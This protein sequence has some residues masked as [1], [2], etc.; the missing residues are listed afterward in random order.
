MRILVWLAIL[1]AVVSMVLAMG[2][3]PTPFPEG[4]D[5]A[6][7]LM[8]GVHDVTQFNIELIDASRSTQT[9]GDYVGAAQ[10]RLTATV[11]HQELVDF[12]EPEAGPL[13]VYSHG[14]SSTRQDGAYLAELLASLGYVVVAVDYPLTN[15]DA[16]GGPLVKDVVNQPGDV[17]FI[18]DSLLGWS[19]DSGHTLA[20]LI[21]PE[22]IGITG[23]SL[24]GMTTMLTAYHP[25]L[26]D[27]RIDAALAIAGPTS[28][29]THRFF[30]TRTDLPFMMIA[31]DLD[32]MVPYDK[33]ALPVLDRIPHS[34]LVTI[35]G[36]SHTGFAGTVGILR[37]LNNPDSVGCY[38]VT[39]ALKEEADEPWFYL[40]G[41]PEQ[42]INYDATNDLCLLDPLP[43]AIN[44]LRQQSI[45]AAVVRSF[46]E[47]QFGVTAQVREEAQTY[48]SSTMGTEIPEANWQSADR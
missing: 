1:L 45:T 9:N 6:A 25:T 30:E 44:P 24:G 47:S 21:D 22:R 36:G 39:R 31:A 26:G 14:F 27:K 5:S 11:W 17:S 19:A 20:G 10:R 28:K 43:T 33:N 38:V 37:W 4:S 29:F 15:L 3:Q 34:Q 35:A 13:V 48:I 7:L 2:R 40:F 46:F 42:G 23:F 32:A 16:P 41:T 12:R 18:I 8:P